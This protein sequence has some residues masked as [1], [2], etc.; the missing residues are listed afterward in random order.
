MSAPSTAAPGFGERVA[1]F[2][3]T[4]KRALALA[5][6]TTVAVGTSVYLVSGPPAR[7]ASSQGGDDDSSTTQ[8]AAGST[9][10]KS[11]KK[12]R[13][14][15]K[16]GAARSSEQDTDSFD[17][18][19]ARRFS[20]AEIEVMDPDTR[21][22]HALDLKKAGNSMYSRKQFDEAVS[23][24]SKAIDFEEQAVFYSNRAAC[25]SNT[26][27]LDKVIEDC[28][29]A[30]KLDKTYLKALNRRAGAYESQGTPEA[31]Y[32]AVCDYTAAAILDG[33]QNEG[34]QA[35]VERV[36][37]RLATV[38]AEEIMKTREPRLPSPTFVKAYLEAFR[39]R[40]SPEI[41]DDASGGD[42]TLKQAFAALD[43]GD[44]A[45]ACTLFNEAILQGVSSDQLRSR[46]L[47]M[48]G[49]FK[50]IMSDA[51]GAL[52][53]LDAA[54]AADPSDAQNWVKK[55]SVHMEL[56]EAADAMHDF[57]EALKVAPTD[58]DVFYHRAQVY[59]ITG[60]YDKAVN[61]YKRSTELDSTFIFSQIQHAVAKYKAGSKEV[62]M[63]LFGRILEQF[64]DRPEAYNYYGE[65]LLDQ[66]QF[67][68][69][70][71][72]FDKAIELEETRHR[73]A[74]EGPSTSGAGGA[75]RVRNVLPMINRALAVFQ[76]R[77][78]F[79]TAERGCK[80]AIELDPLCD[81]GVAT[82]AQLLLQQNRV[83]ESV[84]YFRRSGDLA[85]TETELVN[86]LTF[87]HAGLAQLEFLDKYKEHAISL[88]LTK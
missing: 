88:G 85:R 13:G 11:K 56:S 10:R 34:A 63:R 21:S 45:H 24:Y 16:S 27:E 50:F 39:P 66:Q 30:L 23:C 59:F 6:L 2:V 12:K 31:L 69:A 72:H 28:T 74:T 49:T 9:T 36:M 60:E 20:R 53:D 15:K 14:S 65:V 82:L 40:S 32:R 70:V 64:P 52:A 79:E 67:E 48:S 47:N 25:Y 26:G 8:D 37:K 5:A 7:K 73:A 81:I 58:P 46:A 51:R 38:K 42:A 57:D 1:S 22:R 71:S 84:E 62:A 77:Q 29:S 87:E 33:F 44:Y 55:A 68:H 17:E 3:S 80:E 86:A 43:A 4:H 78:D 19:D 41:S 83:R 76:W 18:N 54:T 61:E 35:T 75:P